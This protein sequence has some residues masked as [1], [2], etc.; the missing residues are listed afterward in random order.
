LPA[1]AGGDTAGVLV[2]SFEL[3]G[4]PQPPAR[5]AE[6]L[7]LGPLAVRV[8]GVAVPVTSGKHRVVLAGLLLN[9]GRVVRSDELAA[10]IWSGSPPVSARPT[11][12]NYVKLL[13]R[14]LADDGS[15]RIV[16]HPGGYQ[17]DV[18]PGELDVSRFETL[19]GTA[20]Q[21][22]RRGGWEEAAARLREALALWRGE[23]LA[24][25]PSDLLLRT[26]PRLAELRLQAL[27]SR[28]DA[29]LQLGRQAELIGELRELAVTFPFRERLHAMLMLALYRDGRQADALA[30]YRQARQVLV[31]ELGAEPGAELS[32]LHQ[33]IL[34]GDRTLMTASRPVTAD[35]PAATAS[36]GGAARAARSA[37]VPAPA[38]SYPLERAVPRQLPAP[39]RHFAGRAGELKVLEELLSEAAGGGG[40]VVISAIGGTA[41]IGKT[42]LAVH[43]AHRVAGRF[44]DGQLYVNL[45]GFDPAGQPVQPA[46]AI[47]DFLYALGVTASQM[48]P[49]LAGMAA[50]YRSLLAGR[51]MLV[52]LDNASDAAQVRPLLPGASGSLVLVTSRHQ[53]TSL[54]VAED[55]QLITLDVLTGTEAHELLAG[56]LG[57]GRTGAEPEAATDLVRLCA[58]LPLALAIAAGRAAASPGV[59]LAVLAAELRQARQRLDVLSADGTVS[60]RAAF[61]WSYRELGDGAARVFRLLGVHPGPDITAAAAASLAG[62]PPSQAGPVLAGLAAEGLLTAHAPGRYALHALL[63]IY[64]AEQARAQDSDT[65]RR[66]AAHR[67]LD[68]YLRTARA[69]ALLIRPSRE[70]VTPPP[71]QPGVTPEQPEDPAQAMGWFAAE[72]QVLLA[73][74]SLAADAHFDIHAW[75]L[76]WAMAESLDRHGYWRD[77]AATQRTAL[78]AAS[79]LGDTAGQAIASRLLATACARLTDYDEARTHLTRCLELSEQAGDQAGQARA[80]RAFSWI[81]EHQNRY[82]EAVSHTEQALSLFQAIADHNGQAD[83]LNSL[84]WHHAQHGFR[85]KAR[86]FCGQALALHRQLGNHHGEAAAW[87]SLGYISHQL[88]RPRSAIMCY[89]HALTL[90]RTLG[91]RYHQADTLTH[92]GDTHQ[93]AGDQP[94][95]R[96]AWHE[97]ASLLS[98]L[99][100]PDEAL[101][102]RKLR[103]STPPRSWPAAAALP[104]HYLPHYA[105]P[106]P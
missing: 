100:H 38:R 91:D 15:S 21:A 14:A 79:R 49:G 41:G 18:R 31:G 64:A 89:Q 63:R 85:H 80:H 8:S 86:L 106:V 96:D 3:D 76:P 62:I 22:A 19:C 32:G 58:G 13:R 66:A 10:M 104:G 94:R 73:V 69:G 20:R 43:W 71:S 61:W 35:R 4:R 23:P 5:V 50:L 28:V 92:L 45:R 30:A 7:L 82:A 87:D 99:N 98:D 40:T 75:Q 2:S 90:F 27:E 29:D 56:R 83:T 37:E 67:V 59:P 81:A 48:P 102:R 53:L 105:R 78:A 72:R 68:H 70:P 54:A 65:G 39:V 74:T 26:V 101:V 34:R 77:Y 6:W 46:E 60:V 52:V 36:R 44:P 88:G 55:A 51:R 103:S 97:A 93:A 17:I 11:L 12:R 42:T 95:A 25:V 33:R 47:R 9:A 16:T 84:G 1:G 57:A 24:D